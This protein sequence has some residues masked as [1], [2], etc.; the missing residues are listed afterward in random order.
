MST[1]QA[2]NFETSVEIPEQ[3]TVTLKKTMLGV[4]GPLGKT[5]KNFKKIPVLI[6]LKI[7]AY[8]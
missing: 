1:E 7:R 8:Q 2:E 4:S 5:F 6:E 3:V